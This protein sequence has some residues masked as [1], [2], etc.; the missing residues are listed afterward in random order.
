MPSG[1]VKPGN[2]RLQLSIT[3]EADTLLRAHA[4]RYK[5]KSEIID[6]LIKQKFGI[7]EENAQ[8]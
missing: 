6:A 1:K 4:P 3:Q 8:T 7:R 2:V 5:Q